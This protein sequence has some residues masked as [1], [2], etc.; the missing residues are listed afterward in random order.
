MVS[1]DHCTWEMLTADETL[2]TLLDSVSRN[3]AGR[4]HHV[5]LVCG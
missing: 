1:M 2:M 4:A 3:Q 5:A